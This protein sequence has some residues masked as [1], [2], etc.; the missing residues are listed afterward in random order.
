MET[1]TTPSSMNTTTERYV[2]F[3]TAPVMR[4]IIFTIGG[5]GLV[6]NIF[7]V[8]V[9]LSGT[10]MRKQL[11]N[12]YIINQSVMDTLVSLFLILTTVFEDD[13]SKFST[14]VDEM[15]CKF[16]LTKLW[17]W[18]AIVSS[19]YNLL[20][21]TMERYLAVVYPI[22]H[23]MRINKIRVVFSVLLVWLIG[24]ALI[25]SFLLPTSGITDDGHCSTLTF[26]PNEK[27]QKVYGIS[28]IFV[29][30]MGPLILLIFFYTRMFIVLR[31]NIKTDRIGGFRG[32]AVQ[33]RVVDT[34][35]NARKNIL[36]TLSI[37]AFFFA[38]CWSWNQT[39]FLMF[40]LGYELVDFTSPFYNFTVVMVFL[41]CCLNPFIYIAKYEEF[42]KTMKALICKNKVFSV[43]F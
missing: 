10:K 26:W 21:L 23:K 20:A 3:K 8:I 15:F 19:T 37:V 33:R 32:Q 2:V 5:V 18:S 1:A 38:F 7:V 40:N 30:F 41:N 42:Q 9:I 28:A 13:S 27:W 31:R 36:K 17:L 6:G 29:Q 16:W 43:R 12:T 34:M 22:W 39:Y 35:G 24:P 14:F 4:N 25:M 11:T